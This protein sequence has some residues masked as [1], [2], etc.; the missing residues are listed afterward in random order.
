MGRFGHGHGKESPAWQHWNR[1]FLA[2]RLQGQLQVR[3]SIR[4][5]H[6]DLLMRLVL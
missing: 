6:F 5:A 3:S 1:R 2:R 4:R